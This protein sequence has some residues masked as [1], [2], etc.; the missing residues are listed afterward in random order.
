VEVNVKFIPKSAIWACCL[1]VL[2]GLSVTAQ[3]EIEKTAQPCDTGICVYWWPKL[4]Q[5]HGW[6][7]DK[8]QSFYSGIYA[9]APDGHSFRNAEAVI[10][11]IATHKRQAPET[12]SLTRFIAADK[13]RFT[14]S[15]PDITITEVSRLSTGDGQRL[16]SFTFLPKSKGSWEVVS[17]GEEGD[18]YL[19]FVLS[20]RTRAGFDKAQ[21]AFR[22]LI[23]A[24]KTNRQ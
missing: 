8:D 11:A 18:Y 16:R 10:Y 9:M 15:D 4:P 12:Q 3:A 2:C 14:A 7:Q 1:A 6:H 24:Y 13:N 23:A 17:Y 20:S 5:I 22:Q 21:P 19:T